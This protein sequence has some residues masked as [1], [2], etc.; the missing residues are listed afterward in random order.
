[1]FNFGG[2]AGGDEGV[3]K[4]PAFNK[5]LLPKGTGKDAFEMGR[6]LGTGSFGRVRVAKYM[7]AHPDANMD[8]DKHVP[9]RVAIKMLKKAAIIKLKQVDHITNEKNILLMLEHP[10]TVRCYGA[11]H[12]QRYL[13][14]VLELVQGGEFFTHLRRAGRFDNDTARFYAAQICDIFD[15]LHSRN[16]VYRD[17][18]PENMLLDKDGYVKL[19]DFGFAK[20]IEFRTDTLCGTPEY[21]APEVLLNKGHGK[22]VDWWTMGILIYEMLVGYPPFVAE[23][24]MEIYKKILQGK[25]VFPKFFDKDAKVLV[26][27]LLQ[28]DLSKRWGN[29]K[30]GVRDIKECRWFAVINFDQLRRKQLPVK[31][32][33]TVKGQDDLSNF[34]SYPDSGDLAPPVHAAHDP[35]TDW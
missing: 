10:L 23:D 8:D 13:Y 29:L 33:P 34:E 11:F 19:T 4:M 26:K 25:V 12:D 9:P 16:T 5:P 7:K 32:K 21:I 1:M 24:P 30:N 28:A 20:I 2:K 15:Y 17:L 18:K 22:P 14:L 27:K 35:F 31:Y 6:T 3:L